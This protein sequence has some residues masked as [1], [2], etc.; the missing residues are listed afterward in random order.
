MANSGLQLSG[1]ARHPLA[2]YLPWRDFSPSTRHG[3]LCLSISS[4][5][6]VSYVSRHAFSYTKVGIRFK[7]HKWM[8]LQYL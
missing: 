7:K 8:I 4:S 1:V 5:F 2:F 3:E 6:L